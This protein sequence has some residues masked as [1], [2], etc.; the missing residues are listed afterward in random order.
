MSVMKKQSSIIN[1]DIKTG[2]KVHSLIKKNEGDSSTTL[3]VK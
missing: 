1:N 2:R 3:R